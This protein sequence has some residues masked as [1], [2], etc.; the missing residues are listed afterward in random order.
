M[1]SRRRLTRAMTTVITAGMRC[2][3]TS[4]RTR[5]PKK[6]KRRPGPLRGERN[7]RA[8]V[9]ERSAATLERWAVGP[10]MRR[11]GYAGHLDSTRESRLGRVPLAHRSHVGAE[12]RGGVCSPH[13]HFARDV[14]IPD[15]PDVEAP[16]RGRAHPA[17]VHGEL[18]GT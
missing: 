13:Y 12:R 6:T 15:S 5:T 10:S 17:P 16:A 18:V 4:P 8:I 9:D 1:D 14:H 7:A 11:P 3:H 2:T